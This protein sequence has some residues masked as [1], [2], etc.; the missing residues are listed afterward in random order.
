MYFYCYCITFLQV[1]AVLQGGIESYR[2]A[3]LPLASFERIDLV[4]S[5]GLPPAIDCFCDL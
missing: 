2:E 3:G 4:S 5:V 1:K